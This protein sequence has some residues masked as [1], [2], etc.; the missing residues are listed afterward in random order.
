MAHGPVANSVTSL[1]LLQATLMCWWPGNEGS[2]NA[3]KL[4]SPGKPGREAGE[5]WDAIFEML[6]NHGIPYNKF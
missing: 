6:L 3:Q 2:L 1:L 4:A 5:I